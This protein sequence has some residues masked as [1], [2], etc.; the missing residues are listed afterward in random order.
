[1]WTPAKYP[2]L[3]FAIVHGRYTVSTLYALGR[4]AKLSECDDQRSVVMYGPLDWHAISFADE[5]EF[6]EQFKFVKKVE[7]KKNAGREADDDNAR[8]QH[9]GTPV[10]GG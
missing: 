4:R 6:V 5:S 2:A 1:M 3:D 10:Q 8:L 9:S 7:Y